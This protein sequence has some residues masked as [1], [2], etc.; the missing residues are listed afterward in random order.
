ML[1][2]LSYLSIYLSVNLSVHLSICSSINR[3]I[4]DFPSDPPGGVSGDEGQYYNPYMAGGW[5]AMAPPLYNEVIEYDDGTPASM[6]QLA[7]GTQWMLVG[8]TLSLILTLR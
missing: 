5:I 1:F 6:S 4:I 8:P 2:Q 3:S 7:K